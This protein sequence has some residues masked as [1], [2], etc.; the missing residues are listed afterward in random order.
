MAQIIR[1]KGIKRYK[2]HC[3]VNKIRW[4]KQE[5]TSF[6]SGNTRCKICT[7]KKQVFNST[8]I[9]SS[10]IK[11]NMDKITFECTQRITRLDFRTIEYFYFLSTNMLKIYYI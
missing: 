2:S 8:I 9:S 10:G 11:L 1:R 5:A 3:R 6:P 7:P 4:K